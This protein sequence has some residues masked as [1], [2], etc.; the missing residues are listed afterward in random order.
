MI[1]SKETIVPCKNK[2]AYTPSLKQTKISSS[3]RY[4]E[5]GD[6]RHQ[7]GGHRPHDEDSHTKGW[8]SNDKC[9]C[10]TI[11]TKDKYWKLKSNK[12]RMKNG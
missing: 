7:D 2:I 11:K 3:D 1:N 4:H 5:D 12:C 10:R 6:H 9:Q 8:R